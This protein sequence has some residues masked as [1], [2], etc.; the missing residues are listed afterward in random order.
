MDTENWWSLR[1]TMVKEEM[2]TF[3]NKVEDLEVNV[4]SPH[5]FN[6]CGL[7]I[8]SEVVKA[9]LFRSRQFDEGVVECG[10]ERL[11]KRLVVCFLLCFD[12]LFGLTRLA[13]ADLRTTTHAIALAWD[14]SQ[15]FNS[16]QR[17]FL[18]PNSTTCSTSFEPNLLAK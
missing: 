17:T 1:Y 10:L 13:L 2:D 18:R 12:G 9:R 15:G 16:S 8:S 11:P 6:G 14:A 3:N 5:K 4:V 7:I